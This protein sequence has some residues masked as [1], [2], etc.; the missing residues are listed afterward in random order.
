[1]L[2]TPS[3]LWHLPLQPLRRLPPDRGGNLVEY[4]LLMAL[5]AIVVFAALTAVG[6]Q[7]SSRLVPIGSRVSS[8]L[9]PIGSSLA[10]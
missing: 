2:L 10:G 3:L 9:V 5:I 6:V 7:V 8:R 4:A 1:M